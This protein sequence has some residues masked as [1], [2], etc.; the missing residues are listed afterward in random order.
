MSSETKPLPQKTPKKKIAKSYSALIPS[1]MTYTRLLSHKSSHWPFLIDFGL[2]ERKRKGLFRVS[3]REEEEESE[4]AAVRG[5]LLEHLRVNAMSLSLLRNPNHTLNGLFALTFGAGRRGFSDEVMGSFLDKSEVT[6][7]VLC[8]VKN[9]QNV[10][11]SKVFSFLLH[12]F[13]F[14]QLLVK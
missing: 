13:S 7:R 1:L 10:D 9:F 3:S 12:S 6:D 8:V 5:A 4:M 2:L 11:P 14:Q